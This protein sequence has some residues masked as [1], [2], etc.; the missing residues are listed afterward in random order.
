MQN[1]RTEIAQKSQQNQK[2]DQENNSLRLQLESQIE[3]NTTMKDQINRHHESVRKVNI[4]TDLLRKELENQQSK[5]NDLQMSQNNEL[6][7]TLLEKN[8]L[9]QR[10]NEMNNHILRLNANNMDIQ[11]NKEKDIR[12]L[13]AQILNLQTQNSRQKQF[14]SKVQAQNDTKEIEELKQARIK[15]EQQLKQQII[16]SKELDKKLKQEFDQRQILNGQMEEELSKFVNQKEKY[17]ERS[18]E[19]QK[20]ILKLEKEVGKINFETENFENDLKKKVQEATDK[21]AE[22]VLEYQHKNKNQKQKI[23][24]LRQMVD[25]QKQEILSLKGNQNNDMEDI[26]QQNPHNLTMTYGKTSDGSEHD[27]KE[28]YNL[29]MTYGKTSDGSEHDSEESSTDSNRLINVPEKKQPTVLSEMT[30]PWFQSF[31]HTGGNSKLREAIISKLQ[32][33][34]RSRSKKPLE[35]K[36]LNPKHVS[37]LLT[38]QKNAKNKK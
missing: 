33:Q 20:K 14:V 4:D 5:F 13:Q 25:Q 34:T 32:K 28:K 23:L 12:S 15:V 38:R 21:I 18:K 11:A 8:Q 22:K 35:K 30:I 17:E 7:T 36:V 3:E 1:L 29:K 19:Y 31:R 24:A 26:N 10:L 9:Q 27:S 2:V 16:I 6:A 37:L